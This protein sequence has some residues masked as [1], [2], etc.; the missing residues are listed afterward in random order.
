[1]LFINIP[2]TPIITMTGTT[3]SI[4]STTS[5]ISIASDLSHGFHQRAND[6][7]HHDRRDNGHYQVNYL[8]HFQVSNRSH[9]TVYNYEML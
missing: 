7:D 4:R 1:M 6:P 8:L 2:I 5:V 9:L 3:A